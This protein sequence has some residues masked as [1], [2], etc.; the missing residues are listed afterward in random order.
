MINARKSGG[1]D[2]IKAN[3]NLGYGYVYSWA[4]LLEKEIDTLQED[5]K[6]DLDFFK[7]AVSRLYEW[8]DIQ[9]ANVQD[10]AE[11]A[12][13]TLEQSD[14]EYAHDVMEAELS[15]MADIGIEIPQ[16]YV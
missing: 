16:E 13:T 10:G 6:I 14:W 5:I 1:Y 11:D 3:T 9:D 2:T 12:L 8:I 15:I 7:I 4:E